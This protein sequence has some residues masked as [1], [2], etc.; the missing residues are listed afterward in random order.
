MSFDISDLCPKCGSPLR[1]QI[2]WP[3]LKTCTNPS[4]DYIYV[5]DRDSEAFNAAANKII[6]ERN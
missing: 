4:C 3:D 1:R 5:T 6:Q 2:D